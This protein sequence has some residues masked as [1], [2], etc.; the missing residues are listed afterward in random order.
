VPFS[1]S[2]VVAGLMFVLLFA[3]WGLFGPWLEA[4]GLRVLFTVPGLVL[5][6][7]FVTLP[8]VA[9]ELIPV[10][11]AIGLLEANGIITTDLLRRCALAPAY[12]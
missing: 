8:F 7:T 3:G 6:T 12:A 11:E 9:R 10:M 2:P 5:V 1:V 4:H